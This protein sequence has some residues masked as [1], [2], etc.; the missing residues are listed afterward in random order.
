MPII[1]GIDEAGYGPTLG[2]FVLSKVVMEI[3]DEY[4]HETNIWHILKDAISEKIQKRGNRI[5]VGDSKKLYQQKT[6]LKM[7][8]EAVLSFV[9]HT[10][11]PVRKF[12]DLLKLF[13][14]YN[15]G[16]LDKYPWYN[17]K[18]LDLPVASNVSA[19]MNYEDILKETTI[20]RDVSILD[21]K[22]HFL[23]VSEINRQIA[24]NGNKSLLLFNSCV[25]HLKEIF[26]L[27]GEHKPKVLID[28]HGG[29][30]YYEKLLTHY[31]KGCKVDSIVEG[32]QLSTYN[33][34]NETNKMDVSFIVGADSKYFPT[35]LASMFSKYIR[36]LFIKLFN[37]FWQEKIRD[38][39]STAGYPEDAR[40]FLSQIHNVRSELNICDDI[41][42][43]S[44]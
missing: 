3:P 30:N 32:N 33:I 15:E 10:K 41:L 42:I 20:S 22:C 14:D 39:K 21:I 9:W 7:L 44:K 8:E 40:R 1:A 29:R 18:D 27:Y 35:A 34:K 19:I 6:G 26:E 25:T 5:I 38:I 28:K 13:T 31:F 36:E 17:G 16:V 37:A 2:P 24:L 43:R 11:G 23:C 12:T 4:H